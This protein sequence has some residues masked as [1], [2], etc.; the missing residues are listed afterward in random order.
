MQNNE[1]QVFRARGHPTHYAIKIVLIGTTNREFCGWSGRM[2]LTI[3]VETKVQRKTLR[4]STAYHL[5]YV[6]MY[7]EQYQI[8]TY[9]AFG[10]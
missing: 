6:G 3:M 1:Q 8:R 10:F 7:V 4:W 2:G 5:A 9:L